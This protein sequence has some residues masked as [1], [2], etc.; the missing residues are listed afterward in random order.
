MERTGSWTM[1]NPIYTPE[2]LETVKV[3]NR[4]PETTADRGAQGMVKLAR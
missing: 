3:V 1:M 2:E 4:P